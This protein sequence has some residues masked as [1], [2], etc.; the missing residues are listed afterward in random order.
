MINNNN[1]SSNSD[2]DMLDKSN[3]SKENTANKVTKMPEDFRHLVHQQRARAQALMEKRRKQAY[4]TFITEEVESGKRIPM[5]KDFWKAVE[6]EISFDEIS[7]EDF[8]FNLEKTSVSDKVAEKQNPATLPLWNKEENIDLIV[9]EKLEVSKKETESNKEE[10]EIIYLDPDSIGLSF[11]EAAQLI[12][13]REKRVMTAREIATIAIN[14]GLVSSA[15]KT[16]DASIA[17]QI[18]TDTRRNPEKTPF[19]IVGPRTY[20]LKEFCEQENLWKKPVKSQ[21]IENN[22]VITGNFSTPSTNLVELTKL[23]EQLAASSQ[24]TLADKIDSNIVSDEDNIK[25]T[26]LTNIEI[27]DEIINKENV[28]DS[29]IEIEQLNL[30]NN[31]SIEVIEEE[32]NIVSKENKRMGYKQAAIYLLQQMQRP[33]TAKE[34]VTIAI[35]QGLIDS[36]SK[37]PDA[38]LAGQIYTEIQ[39]LGEQSIF[40]MVAPRTYGLAE[41]YK[42]ED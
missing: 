22:V 33:M 17:G 41:W 7:K 11:R 25:I 2:N 12:L 23:D 1:D 24:A 8:N 9:E 32:S 31:L 38:S 15:G 26:E 3:S 6:G 28:L 21:D 4:Q 20:A 35:E 27:V 42:H 16:P 5:P 36:N 29:N 14:E 18:Y 39:K 30:S 40:R 19:V 37:K 10:N 13:S 34:I